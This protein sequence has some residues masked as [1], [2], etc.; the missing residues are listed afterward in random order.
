[1]P[2]IWIAFCAKAPGVSM[3]TLVMVRSWL[4]PNSRMSA[5]PPAGMFAV[6]LLWNWLFG[7]HPVPRTLA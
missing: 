4:Y 3:T 6:A 7:L 5:R 2:R 1:M